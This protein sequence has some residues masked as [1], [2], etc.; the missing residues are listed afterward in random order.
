MLYLF[1]L[2]YIFPLSGFIAVV[3]QNIL[4][5]L[6]TSSCPA[7]F[8]PSDDSLLIKISRQERDCGIF[9]SHYLKNITDWLCK[10]ISVLIGIP[11]TAD[12]CYSKEVPLHVCMELPVFKF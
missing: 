11:K 6:Y 2:T 7:S 5:C 1:S 3:P 8:T 10:T 12:C 9:L 4:C